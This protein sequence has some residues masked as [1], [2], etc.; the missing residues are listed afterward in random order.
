MGRAAIIWLTAVM[1]MG[2]AGCA[3]P[4]ASEGGFDSRDPAAKLYAI[5]RAG[6]QRDRSAI[7]HLIEQL[8]SDDEAVRMFAIIALEKIT[9]TRLGYSPY[10]PAWKREPAVGEWVAAYKN[11]E[12]AGTAKPPPP[13]K[14]T[15]AAGEGAESKQ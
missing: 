5:Q 13:E 1:A 15:Q 4:P 7:P 2:P 11:G 14:Q 8:N 12:F 10:D 6:E 3:P 9:G